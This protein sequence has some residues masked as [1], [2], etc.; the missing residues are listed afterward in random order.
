MCKNKPCRKSHPYWFCPLDVFQ[1]FL[2]GLRFSFQT[3][4]NF[5]FPK[6][7]S[8]HMPSP[9]SDDHSEENPI[10]KPDWGPTPTPQVGRSIGSFGASRAAAEAC[11]LAFLQGRDE[12][13][14]PQGLQR[15]ILRSRDKG[16]ERRTDDRRTGKRPSI[17]RGSAQRGWKTSIH[18][19]AKHVLFGWDLLETNQGSLDF[20]IYTYIHIVGYL[21]TL[22]QGL[23]GTVLR[24]GFNTE[25]T[26]FGLLRALPSPEEASAD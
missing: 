2:L 6:S 10:E 4:P 8:Q 18:C 20:P 7:S 3:A 13:G 23:Q 5:Q 22:L 24:E 16:S 26:G 11:D 12:G 1:L 9:Q 19:N 15:H 17:N 14:L 25:T 21:F